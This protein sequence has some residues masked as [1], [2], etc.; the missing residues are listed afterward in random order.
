MGAK[1]AIL[2]STVD[3]LM[4][5]IVFKWL[6]A[7]DLCV[8]KTKG[9][10]VDYISVRCLRLL[11]KSRILLMLFQYLLLEAW[12]IYAFRMCFRYQR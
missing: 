4:T 6:V 2:V 10:S 7:E 3:R 5:V 8:E 1:V 11:R 9:G 12:Y